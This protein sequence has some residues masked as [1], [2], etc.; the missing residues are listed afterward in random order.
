VENREKGLSVKTPA[1]CRQIIAI[2]IAIILACSFIAQMISTN[3]GQIKIEKVAFDVRGASLSGE[4]YYPA[5][6]TDEDSYPAVVVVA[7]AGIINYQMRSFGEELAKKGYV[8]LNLNAYG[9][10]ASETPVYNEN[11]QGVLEYNIFG[12]PMGSLDAVHYLRTV[13]FIDS[14]RIGLVGHSQ[15]SRRAGYAA[16]MDCGYYSFN[17]VMLNVLYEKFNID[18]TE[19]QLSENADAIASDKLN[20]D[21]LLH[22]N[23]LKEEYYDDY[24]VM[25]KS[26][27]LVG[28]TA[29]YVYP[30]SMVNV[31]GHDVL[32]SCKVN[33][34]II[35]G[36]Y[37]FGYVSFNNSEDA[38]N[39]MYIP[40][41]SDII[42]GGYYTLDDLTNTSANIGMFRQDTINTNDSLRNAIENRSLRVI[43]QTGE[44]HSKN[45]F[46]RRTSAMIVDYFNQTL[47]NHADILQTG[48][49]SI[50]FVWR[51][52]S[53]QL[54]CCR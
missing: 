30:T 50:T 54:P 41:G 48:E 25:V 52:I 37:D 35:N 32:R 11:D 8:V 51:E 34:G 45:F 47:N 49:S 40:V 1:G 19:E 6:T 16:L 10:G 38:K 4:L 31:A 3:G 27:C 14:E 21:Q 17:D 2:L 53:T 39:G 29:Q 18:L 28:S 46:S 43:M 5:F 24:R 22:Y 12:T 33:I 13:E 23:T 15:G 7:G 36:T 44:T 42:Q 26:I 20:A 9:S